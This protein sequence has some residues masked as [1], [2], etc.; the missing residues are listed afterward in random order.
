MIASVML[1]VGAALP[2]RA[3]E[4]ALIFAGQGD[5]TRTLEA[6]DHMAALGAQHGG[7]YLNS[8]ELTPLRSDP[9]LRA[10]R[11]RIGLPN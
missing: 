2:L 11:N 10:L 1:A 6:L 5:T 7:M 3:N 9:R 4:Q 8:P